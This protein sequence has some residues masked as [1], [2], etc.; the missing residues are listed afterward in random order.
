MKRTVGEQ[1]ILFRR[2]LLAVKNYGDG[3]QTF[4]QLK[5]E[6]D[7]ALA[8]PLMSDHWEEIVE[9][10]RQIMAAPDEAGRLKVRRDARRRF[11]KKYPAFKSKL[12]PVRRDKKVE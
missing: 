8:Q 10:A 12:L 3:S 1:M 5:A 2:V 6:V 4:D 9:T 7:E 11:D